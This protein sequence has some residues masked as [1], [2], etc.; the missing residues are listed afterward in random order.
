[1]SVVLR[2]K[3][4]D[5]ALQQA[6]PIAGEATP[7]VLPAPEPALLDW[8]ALTPAAD[9]HLVPCPKCG[10]PNGLSASTCW[11]CEAELLPLERYRRQRA[12]QPALVPTHVPADADESLPVLTASVGGN[13]PL[14]R[15]SM[16]AVPA[17]APLAEPAPAGRRHA[18]G[19]GA[20]ILVVAVATVGA[21]VYFDAPAPPGASNASKSGGFIDPP[22]PAA[23]TAAR[24]APTAPA[25][26]GNL[27]SVG[28]AP[29]AGPET[30]TAALRALAVEPE[31]H[32]DIPTAAQAPPSAAPA[33][34]APA[35]LKA[36]QAGRAR[37]TPRPANVA[38]APALPKGDRPDPSPA[39]QAPAPARPCTPT[40]AA[41][42]LC[43]GPS[44]APTE[45]KE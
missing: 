29:P 12:L 26:P 39:W 9:S 19:A 17:S 44:L 23:L 36:T 24:Q 21:V 31:V 11:S 2:L 30:R 33:T 3:T 18:W 40:V 35:A 6:V 34:A 10:S 1:M 20:S 45:S 32:P 22:Q 38:A 43:A 25:A 28:D 13:A 41:L 37:S 16:A 5:G 14:T 4:G 7:D 27:A 42:G 15:L 8:A